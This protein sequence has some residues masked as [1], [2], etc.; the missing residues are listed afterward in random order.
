MKTPITIVHLYAK[1]MNI[2]GDNGNVLVLKKRLEWRGFT[3]EVVRIGVGDGMPKNVHLV[4]GGGGQDAGQQAI[5]DDLKTKQPALQKLA[6]N[7]VP[8]LMICGMYQM[9]G[10]AFITADGE[11]IEGIGVLD[12]TTSASKDRLVGNVHSQTDY[13]TLVG[14]ENH[15]GRTS[16]GANAKAF[17]AVPKG[18]GNDGL[19]TTEGARFNNVFGSYLHGPVLA[20]S[21]KFADYLLRLALD[22]AGDADELL[23]LD[24]SLAQRAAKIAILRPR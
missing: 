7:G 19:D 2:Y 23:A 16:L 22:I 9:L 18:Q 13:G 21:P 20:K 6:D 12:V 4:I 3:V 15:S 11:K 14:Y 5:A 10:R 1:E 8:M 24:D 17:G